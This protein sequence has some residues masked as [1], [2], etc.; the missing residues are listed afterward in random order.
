MV[1]FCH[2]LHYNQQSVL[3][4]DVAKISVPI[5]GAL[6]IAL[7]VFYLNRDKERR[8]KI[9]ELKNEVIGLCSRAINLASA[10]EMARIY[11]V[12]YDAAS[13]IKGSNESLPTHANNCLER[14]NALTHDFNMC[15][16]DLIKGVSNLYI[17]L[18]QKEKNF[19]Y[20]KM[21][22]Y[23]NFK[24]GNPPDNYEGIIDH[25]EIENK[26]QENLKTVINKT[27]SDTYLSSLTEIQ[28]LLN[29]H[30]FNRADIKK[31]Q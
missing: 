2:F 17:F 28:R 18:S 13:K 14:E 23:E 26:F 6:V 30:L 29:P 10:S 20:K 24:I 31:M 19:I 1:I 11:Y 22:E 8:N 21:K 5:F 12:Y 15:Q 3:S 27:S 25:V 4:S 9:W 16:A 7:I